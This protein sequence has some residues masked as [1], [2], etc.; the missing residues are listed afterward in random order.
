MAPTNPS[1][2]QARNMLCVHYDKWGQSPETLREF[3]LNGGH[4]RTRERFLAL[5]EISQ[6]KNATQVSRE[7]GRNHQTVMDWVHRYN[8]EGHE[9]LFYRH[10]G[11]SLPLFARK[12]PTAS[13]G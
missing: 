7:T 1:R 12:S 3:A 8:N 13:Q 6:G 2:K 10:T 9:S 4:P 5:F 11:G